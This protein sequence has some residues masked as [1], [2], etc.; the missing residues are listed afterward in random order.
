MFGLEIPLF[1][2]IFNRN[3]ENVKKEKKEE[4]RSRK[5]KEQS[6]VRMV[7]GRW[8]KRALTILVVRGDVSRDVAGLF[9]LGG[10]HTYVQCIVWSRLVPSLRLVSPRTRASTTTQKMLLKKRIYKDKQRRAK[11]PITTRAL[12]LIG[13]RFSPFVMYS[14]C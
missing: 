2:F 7:T 13:L 12:S 11:H 14:L 3:F 1:F 10:N 9:G 8:L 4:K 5:W 6:Q